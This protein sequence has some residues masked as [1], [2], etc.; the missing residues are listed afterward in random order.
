MHPLKVYIKERFPLFHPE[1]WKRLINTL[2]KNG[3]S[4]KANA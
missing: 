4:E 1:K 3:P 2:L